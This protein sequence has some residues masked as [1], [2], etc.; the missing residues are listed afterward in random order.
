[1]ANNVSEYFELYSNG[2]Q[3]YFEYDTTIQ[4]KEIEEQRGWWGARDQLR[5]SF[6]KDLK[7]GNVTVRSDALADT[8]CRSVNFKEKY[9]WKIAYG[10][11][12]FAQLRCQKAYHV[13]EKGDSIIVWFAPA[14]PVTDG[15]DDFA[16][17]P[18][19]IMAVEAPAF[20]YIA[21]S[22]ELGD[23]SIP[24]QPIDPSKCVKES[25]F[26]EKIRE[27]MIRR[28]INRKE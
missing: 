25:T 9:Q 28:Y 27:E 14:I 19:L 22:V 2:I 17:A 21:E 20:N 13:N 10:E 8:I 6:A 15:P 11:K 26:Q 16:G 5:L 24:K 3:S 12:V 23:I 18:G 7:S 4:I 1:M